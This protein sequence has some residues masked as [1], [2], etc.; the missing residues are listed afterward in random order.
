[1]KRALFSSAGV[2]ALSVGLAGSAVTA[3]DDAAAGDLGADIKLGDIQ[4]TIWY[5][6]VGTIRPY[7]IGSHTCNIGDA[8]LSWING[9]TPGMAMNAYRLHD[10]RLMQIGMGW[11]KH[12]CCVINGNSPAVCGT[13]CSA[14]GF[15]LRPGCLD[16]YTAGFNGGQHRLGPRSGINPYTGA[17][18]PVPTFNGNSID[19]RLQIDESDMSSDAYTH[20]LYF[21]EGVYV[22]T[23]DAQAGNWLNNASYRRVE[24]SPTY[25][26]TLQDQ[27]DDATPAIYAWQAYGN[28]IGNPDKSVEIVPVD[29]PGEGR[30][31]AA[32]RISDNGDGTWRYEYALYNLNSHRS[33]GAFA[34][35]IEDGTTISNIGFH[36][37]PYHSGE[38][39]SN[40]PWITSRPD[41]QFA[42]TSPEDFATNPDT[43]ALRWGTMYNYWFDADRPPIEVDATLELFRPGSPDTVSFTTIAPE[44]LP[45]CVGDLNG[46]DV[47]EVADLLILLQRWGACDGC[48]ADLSDDG[49]VD[50]VDLLILISSAWGPCP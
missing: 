13:S 41:G 9:G 24:I 20:A 29:V 25:V 40:A 38:P 45:A 11:V 2:L 21:V 19:R 26:M 36:S 6:P 49:Q 44:P 50:V 14:N 30:F 4:S 32:S 17:F 48:D 16:V 39:Y 18:S 22:S 28:G 10:G 23:E 15:G 1:M 46:D 12:A 47:V 8:S 33:A 5:T 43:N 27:V 35:P 42:W 3:A 34:L 31:F 7:A 37:P